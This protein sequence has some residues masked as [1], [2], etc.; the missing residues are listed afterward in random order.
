MFARFFA[1]TVELSCQSAVQNVIDQ[2]GFAGARDAG[3]NRHHAQRKGDVKIL[4]IIF[5]RTQNRDRVAVGM[6]ALRPHVD[7]VRPEM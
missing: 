2:G 7:L 1:R 5:A 6:A 3:H 4:E